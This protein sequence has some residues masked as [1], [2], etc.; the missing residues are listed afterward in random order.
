MNKDST[1]LYHKLYVHLMDQEESKSYQTKKSS[2]YQ[3]IQQDINS[4]STELL[5]QKTSTWPTKMSISLS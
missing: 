5:S 1:P 2:M 3:L 4:L